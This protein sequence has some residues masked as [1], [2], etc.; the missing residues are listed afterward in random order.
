MNRTRLGALMI[1]VGVSACMWAC[2]DDDDETPGDT[3]GTGGGGGSSGK[4]G[5]GGTAGKAGSSN[6]GTAGKG[7]GGTA[8]KGGTGPELGGAGAGGT[9]VGGAGAGAGGEPAGGGGAGGMGGETAGGAAGAAGAG[10]ALTQVEGCNA[11][12]DTYFDVNPAEC[13]GATGATCATGACN[14]YDAGDTDVNA[15]FVEY[16][17]CAAT[18]LSASDYVCGTT[19]GSALP[20]WPV[21]SGACETKLCAWTCADG[22]T[23]GD[24]DVYT[25]C[26]C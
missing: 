6:G 11:V 14:G 2:G 21:A 4:G 20:M 18:K 9:E 25:R 8:G 19:G 16:L 22:G 17:Q 26:G 3:A 5:S 7:S 1:A 10:S 24:F 12:C 15:L 23:Q 13:N